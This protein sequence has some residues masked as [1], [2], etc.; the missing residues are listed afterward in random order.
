MP[1]PH[2]ASTPGPEYQF[3]LSATVPSLPSLQTTETDRQT[4]RQQ[5]RDPPKDAAP[6]TSMAGPGSDPGYFRCMPELLPTYLTLAVDAKDMLHARRHHHRYSYHDLSLSLPIHNLVRAPSLPSSPFPLP[7]SSPTAP[8]RVML[9]H[10]ARVAFLSNGPPSQKRSQI[11]FLI[12]ASSVSGRRKAFSLSTSRCPSF[13]DS[14]NVL[15]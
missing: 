8:A 13:L 12:D 2:P 7:P 5:D 4:D 3:S 6:P 11:G 10:G 15:L 9:V 14:P 1:L